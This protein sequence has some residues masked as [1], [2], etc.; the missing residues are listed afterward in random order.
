M[1]KLI[2]FLLTVLLINSFVGSVQAINNNEIK[3]KNLKLNKDIK[4]NGVLGSSMF[5]FDVDSKWQ[6]QKVDF[7][8][9][10][11]PSQI[12]NKD[13]STLTVLVNGNQVYSSNLETKKSFREIL[14]INIPLEYVNVGFNEIQIKTYKRITDKPCTDD[15][16]TANWI[17]F[18]KESFVNLNFKEKQQDIVLKDF[19]YPFMKSSDSNLTNSSIVVPDKFTSEE[20]SVAMRICSVFGNGRKSENIDTKIL[21]YS[22]LKDEKNYNL[23]FIASYKS[24]PKEI[25]NLLTDNERNSV[26]DASII[27]LTN[28]PYNKDRK[29]L[30]I[31]SE[32]KELI[33]RG[34]NLL[35]NKEVL[36]QVKNSSIVLKEDVLLKNNKKEKEKISFKDLG[37]GNTTL[38]GAFNQETSYTIPIQRDKYIKEGASLVLNV[39]YSKNIDF[40]KALLTVYINDIPIG[41][42]KLSEKTADNDIFQISIPKEVRNSNFYEV[43]I[44]FDLR[45][46]D[47]YCNVREENTPWVYISNDSYLRLPNDREKE[48]IFEKYPFPFIENKNNNLT[49]VISDKSSSRELTWLG[50]IM[51]YM[52]AFI[53]DNNTEINIVRASEL[54]QNDKNKNL[55]ILGSPSKNILIKE[56]NNHMHIKYN[57]SYSGFESNDKIDILEEYGNRTASIQLINSPYNSKSNLMIIT[58]VNEKDINL[59]EKYLKDIN[60]IGRLKGNAILID[61]DGEIKY[62]YYGQEYKNSFEKEEKAYSLTKEGRNLIIFLISLLAILILISGLYLG[63]YKKNK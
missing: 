32:N 56:L 36:S 63:R 15:T 60:L 55:I 10:Y 46:K 12:L 50:N 9:I 33:S 47:T 2:I 62:D 34:G 1:K 26:K 14:N 45:L 39:R 58:A 4:S 44:G 37:Y 61:K 17:L 3:S 6:L 43:K 35:S 29:I 25:L 21:R 18:H 30:I 20:A 8:L 40:D 49:F 19:P 48:I 53:E 38:S 57:K 41:S 54:S 27:K 13:I 42:K 51:I 11:T 7:N 28:S 52:G 22:D 23:I 31:T 5:Y 59:A 16:N 24:L